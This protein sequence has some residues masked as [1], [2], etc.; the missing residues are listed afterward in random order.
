ML[1]VWVFSWMYYDSLYEYL[2]SAERQSDDGKS[3]FHKD[4]FSQELRN[5][6]I[7]FVSGGTVFHGLLAIQD[8]LRSQ[9]H[10]DGRLRLD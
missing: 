9:Y 4:C 3:H 1:C 8:L 7:L 6:L 10:L 5:E 2:G